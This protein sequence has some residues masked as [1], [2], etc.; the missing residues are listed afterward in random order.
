MTQ[1]STKIRLFKIKPKWLV[2]K[3]RLFEK[4][5]VKCSESIKVGLLVITTLLGDI[6]SPKKKL[7]IT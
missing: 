5:Y 4:I 1:K 7:N 2:E 6:N 3:I